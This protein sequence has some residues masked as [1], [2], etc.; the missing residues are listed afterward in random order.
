MVNAQEPRSIVSQFCTTK[1]MQ[2]VVTDRLRRNPAITIYPTPLI[3]RARTLSIKFLSA[4]VIC[5]QRDLPLRLKHATSKGPATICSAECLTWGMIAIGLRQDLP[6]TSK[7]AQANSLCVILEAVR[8]A[9]GFDPTCR[10][11]MAVMHVHSCSLLY[12]YIYG[13][14]RRL[15]MHGI[16]LISAEGRIYYI[17]LRCSTK[18]K[19]KGYLSRSPAQLAQPCLHKHSPTIHHHPQLTNRSR[20]Q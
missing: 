6:Q 18:K 7:V 15:R 13:C 19:I 5:G 17:Q 10:P 9:I 14:P 2:A 8:R 12:S 3:L 1:Y 16:Y 4:D 11:S 20:Q